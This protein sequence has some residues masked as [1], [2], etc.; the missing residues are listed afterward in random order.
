MDQPRESIF[1]I[2]AEKI[3]SNPYQPRREFNEGAIAELAESVKEYGILE[4]LIVSRVEQDVPTGTKVSYQLVAGERRLLAAKKAGLTTVP[5]IIRQFP[6]ERMKLEIALVE[7]IQREDLNAMERAR[8]FAR[9]A[10]NFGL[11]QREI[12]LRVGKSRESVAN[13]M[14]LL[15]LPLDAQKA[16]ERGDISEGHA[17]AILSVPNAEK[18]RALLG[19]VL[20]KHFTVRETEDM[21]RELGGGEERFR[22]KVV[23][24]PDPVT[25]ELATQLEEKLGAKVVLK[26]YGGKGEIAIKFQ[27][28]EELN[29]IINKIVGVKAQY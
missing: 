23:V 8:A 2:E 3:E 7:N 15:Q 11:A 10:D 18:Q 19:E 13:T 5:A 14:R 16:L 24:T 27:S 20:A 17:R 26:K 1:Y 28:P 9:L 21:A 4:P 29:E 25:Q 6:E 22:P 12:A